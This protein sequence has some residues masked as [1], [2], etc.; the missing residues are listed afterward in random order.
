MQL[1]AE[2]ARQERVRAVWQD[3]RRNLQ[4]ERSFAED[5]V[6]RLE[7][8]RSQWEQALSIVVAYPHEPFQ[9]EVSNGLGSDLFTPMTSRAEAGDA[10]RK[11]TH[12]YQSA[13]AFE[14]RRLRGVLARYRGLDLVVVAHP[15]FASD[16]SLALPDG[17]TLDAVNAGTDKG[18]WQS[19]G[20]TV[21][22]ISGAIERLGE[23]ITVAQARIETIGT[24]LARLEEWDG[25]AAYDEAVSELRAVNAAFAATEEEADVAQAEARATDT[26]EAVVGSDQERNERPLEAELLALARKERARSAWGEWTTLIPPAPASLAWMAA[27]IER[28]AAANTALSPR[29]PITSVPATV[30]AG[31]TRAPQNAG[32]ACVQFGE[33]LSQ[34]RQAKAEPV[35]PLPAD[36]EV[37]QL[38]LF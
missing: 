36:A 4:I 24:E 6:R 37:S 1:E 14:R 8:R 3:T 21:N 5:E 35:A 20:R 13:A 23:R 15:V 22:D 2:I 9:V 33:A 29:E 32:K 7:S 38:P 27:E 34:R 12:A 19:V 11:L 28:R 10:V 25:Q 16:L 30:V 31:E 17:A 18:I 26:D